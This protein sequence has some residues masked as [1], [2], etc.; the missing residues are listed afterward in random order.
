VKFQQHN[1]SSK[2]G[3][4]KRRGGVSLIALEAKRGQFDECHVLA[5]KRVRKLLERGRPSRVLEV[6]CLGG[7]AWGPKGRE[8]RLGGAHLS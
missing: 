5:I 1:S 6:E 8:K 2:N 7:R 4:E 3:Q